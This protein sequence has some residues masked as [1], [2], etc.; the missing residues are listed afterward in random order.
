MYVIT[1]VIVRSSL[2][3]VLNLAMTLAENN[4]SSS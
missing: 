2:V 1:T 4:L 3:A